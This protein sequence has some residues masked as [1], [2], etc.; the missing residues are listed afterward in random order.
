MRRYNMAEPI[1]TLA[2]EI[3]ALEHYVDNPDDLEV[4]DDIV[5]ITNLQS[6]EPVKPG[7]EKKPEKKEVTGIDEETG[8]KVSGEES[9]AV[10]E[11]KDVMALVLKTLEELKA[12]RLK[13]VAPVEKPEEDLLKPIIDDTEIDLL[14]GTS[15]EDALQTPEGFKILL[16]NIVSLYKRS[17]Q[18]SQEAVYKNVPE[19]LKKHVSSQ[20]EA[21]ATARD[22]YAKN[23]DLVK[24]KVDVAASANL[25]AA[26]Y[27]GVAGEEFFDLVA[28]HVRFVKKLKQKV[29]SAEE[30]DVPISKGK[31]ALNKQSSGR[32]INLTEE[33]KLEGFEAEVDA[34][35][36]AIEQE[37]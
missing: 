3:T 36:T 18:L 16:G 30:K 10:P 37:E 6:N 19:I 12:G 23:T 15:M 14:E 7:E 11:T 2:E 4:D 9:E 26:T 8:K 24:Y 33:P 27:P 17:Q 1:N 20:V 21:S 31:P 34:M 29:E 22:F 35:I 32:L 25:I 5:D 13:E 28:N